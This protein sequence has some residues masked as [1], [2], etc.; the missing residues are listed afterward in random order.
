MLE[1]DFYHTHVSDISK[2]IRN[3]NFRVNSILRR[4]ALPVSKISQLVSLALVFI[5]LI[6][7]FGIHFYSI[8]SDIKK[9][10]PFFIFLKIP[11]FKS[12]P[13]A[14]FSFPPIW[15]LALL[16]DASLLLQLLFNILPQLCLPFVWDV[17]LAFLFFI[18]TYNFMLLLLKLLFY[19][20]KQS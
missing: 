12:C 10:N 6:Y 1:I 16:P 14:R 11:D 3:N 2:T 17:C 18:L 5:V 4:A 7:K 9:T 19:N 15:K 13:K 20:Q 8:N